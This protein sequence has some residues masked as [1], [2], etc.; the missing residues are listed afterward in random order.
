[1]L[2]I[3]QL[4]K[5]Y[6]NSHGIFDISLDCYPSEVCGIIGDNGSGKSTLL[7]SLA[8]VNAIDAGDVLLDGAVLA[9]HDIGFL[10]ENKAIIEELTAKEYIRL[11]ARMKQ[12]EDEVWE[13]TCIEHCAW[14]DAQ[15]L[16]PL[17]IK[18]L[19]KGNKQKV[20]ILAACIHE[21]KVVLLDEPFSGLDENNRKHVK[22]FIMELKNKNRI[23]IITSHKVDDVEDVADSLCWMDQGKISTKKTLQLLK[24][25]S[26]IIEVSVS[27]DMV[28]DIKEEKGVIST[29][30]NGNISVYLFDQAN[31]AHQFVRMMLKRR[32]TQTITIRNQVVSV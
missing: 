16:L 27:S 3:I 14:L 15:R 12:I 22:N 2:K 18:T 10:P 8:Q 19:S 9:L 29:Q 6:R 5:K 17:K 31:F 26:S 25:E 21:P 4:T 23:V 1:M 28:H 7:K 32:E 20:Q 24:I 11:I 30:R 13:Q